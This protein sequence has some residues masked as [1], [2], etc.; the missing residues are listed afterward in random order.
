ME[1]LSHCTPFDALVDLVMV[2]D[3]AVNSLKLGGLCLGVSLIAGAAGV[4][5]YLRFAGTQQQVGH[6]KTWEDAQLWREASCK[7]VT[8]GVSCV[9]DDTGSTCGGLG[10]RNMKL[11]ELKGAMYFDW[12]ELSVCPGTYWCATE[13]EQCTCDG[14]VTYATELFDGKDVFDH[15]DMSYTVKGA[16]KCG[17]D[18]SGK[19]YADPAPYHIKHCFCTPQ[20]VL[21]QLHAQTSTNASKC[22]QEAN[23][24]YSGK[25]IAARRLTSSPRRRRTYSYTPWA[26]VEVDVPPE[27]GLDTSKKVLTCAYEFGN[28]QASQGMYQGDDYWT[29]GGTDL[30]KLIETWISHGSCNVRM[31]D[32]SGADTCAV[33]FG[34]LG[35]LTERQSGTI[36]WSLVLVIVCSLAFLFCFGCAVLAGLP[37]LM[38]FFR[39][40]REEMRA[41]AAGSQQG[42]VP[43]PTQG[44]MQAGQYQ[45]VPQ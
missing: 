7:V 44:L 22:A 39:E 32:Q 16:I 1:A 23:S 42:S 36:T 13:G 4:Q 30:A 2:Q 35:G 6:T 27:N 40:L 18:N 25:P 17:T 31:A 12:D 5:F 37:P 34:D 43:P 3:A 15:L 41:N 26:L 20:Q 8:A 24:D 29:G 38:I 21:K 9:E 11:T 45:S 14:K 33:S 10:K 19:P 28:P